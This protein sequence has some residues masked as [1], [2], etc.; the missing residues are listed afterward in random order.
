MLH[1]WKQDVTARCQDNLGKH[2]NPALRTG[3]IPGS[4]LLVFALMFTLA[5]PAFVQ[6]D[7]KGYRVFTVAGQWHR[8]GSNAPL[9]AGDTVPGD[10]QLCAEHAT[11]SDSLTLI[12]IENATAIPIKCT[13]AQLTICRQWAPI[14]GLSSQNH[15]SFLGG[16]KPYLGIITI[17]FGEKTPDARPRW[18]LS[19]PG[20]RRITARPSRMCFRSTIV[21]PRFCPPSC[22]GSRMATTPWKSSIKPRQSLFKY[23]RPIF[24]ELA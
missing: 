10:A 4:F 21:S 22:R 23:S 13:D 7:T 6:A 11:A 9:K 8:S 1:D 19:W 20:A 18:Y 15:V 16:I 3:T 14:P 12:S 5:T 17:L 2:R 24:R